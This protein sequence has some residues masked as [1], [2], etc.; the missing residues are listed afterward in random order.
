MNLNV[1]PINKFRVKNV[2]I[3]CM[4]DRGMK[5]WLPFSSLVEQGSFLDRMIYEKNKI[6]KPRV[7][8]E[9][10]RK[11][12]RLLKEYDGSK[13]EMKIYVDGYLYKYYGKIEKIDVSKK[14]IFL[15]DIHIPIKNII[16]IEDPN[17]FADIL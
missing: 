5:K 2:I 13:I 11:I 1:K 15:E 12:D 16:D 9:Q 3:L 7:S 17:P 14:Q 10:A 4:A 6:D 8:V